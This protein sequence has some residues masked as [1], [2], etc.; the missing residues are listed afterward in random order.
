MFREW[1]DLSERCV[2]MKDRWIDDVRMALEELGGQAH[3]NQIYPKV[4]VIREK[5]G[6]PIGKLEEWVR[7]TLQQNSREKGHN[8]FEPV[9]PVEERRGIWRLK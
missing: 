2:R 8:I 6:A 7:N 5:K 3:L 4:R 1:A 9:Y